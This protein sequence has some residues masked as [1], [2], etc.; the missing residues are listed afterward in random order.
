M[1]LADSRKF[2]RTSSMHDQ[3]STIKSRRETEKT[4]PQRLRTRP[5][6]EM[7]TCSPDQ[8]FHERKS[9]RGYRTR[10]LTGEPKRTKKLCGPKVRPA[11][12]NSSEQIG[13]PPTRQT[14][15]ERKTQADLARTGATAGENQERG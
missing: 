7:K 12:G 13:P 8:R 2:H 10:D 4:E 5:A 6:T 9:K 14:E 1:T 3:K 11:K 15:R